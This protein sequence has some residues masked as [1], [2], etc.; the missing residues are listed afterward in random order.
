MLGMDFRVIVSECDETVAGDPSP[1]ML[2]RELAMRKAQA[3]AD[4]LPSE[5]DTIVI[6]ADTVVW[7]G[8]RALGKPRDAADAKTTI[9]SLAGRA[10]SVF[11]GIALVGII[12]G[13]K[14]CVADA[15][16][17]KVVFGDISDAEA[18]HYAKS[19]E[20]D[21]KAGSYAVQGLGGIF[22]TELHGDYY[23]V[24]GLPLAALRTLLSR[25]FGLDTVDYVGKRGI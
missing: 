3:V 20:P 24:V 22:V 9:L 15:V 16:E 13:E 5:H 10:H 1:D 17:T 25:E 21:D 4:T 19:G 2:V 18:E 23:N 6:G 7:D 8:I 11:T 14:K 12:G